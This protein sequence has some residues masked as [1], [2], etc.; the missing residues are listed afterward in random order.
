MSQYEELRRNLDGVV[1]K[2]SERSDKEELQRPYGIPK[3]K[4]GES[5]ANVKKMEDCVGRVMKEQDLDKVAAIRICKKSLFGS[6]AG[7][8]PKGEGDLSLTHHTPEERKK[9]ETERQASGQTVPDN[10]G[11]V[12][13]FK[14]NTNGDGKTGTTDRHFHKIEKWR[15]LAAADDQHVHML[16]GLKGEEKYP[17]PKPRR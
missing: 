10:T 8:V 13:N 14:V 11:H 12:H 6:T 1:A 3:E 4:G 15:V 5:P 2:T 7:E 17:Y 16:P 9:K